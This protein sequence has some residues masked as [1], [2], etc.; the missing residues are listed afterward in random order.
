LAGSASA[1][2][3]WF[4]KKY[5]VF[6]GGVLKQAK[7]EHLIKERGIQYWPRTPH[8]KLATDAETLRAIAQRC[9]E[10]ATFC[11]GKTT[12]DQL[13]TFKLTVGDDDRNR[14][15]LSAFASKTSRNQPSNSKFAFGLNAAFCSV[16]KP[17]FGRAIA[18]LDFS[19]QEFAIAAYSSG[20][21]NMIQAYESGDP[22]SDWARKSG[23]MPADGNKKTHPGVRAV[24]KRASLGVIYG[25]GPETMGEYVG[26]STA[27]AREL[28]RSHR[29]TFPTFWRWSNAVYNSAIVTR[30][31]QTVF[32]WRMH[33]RPDA[34]MR[35]LLNYPMQSNGAEMLRLSCCYAVDRG[36]HIVAPI[37]DAILLESSSDQIDADIA[38]LKECMIAASRAVLGGPAVRVDASDPIHYPDRY[39]DG[40]DG[41]TELWE[42]VMSLLEQLKRRTA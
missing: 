13:K 9:P 33:V 31:L 29:Q 23:A 6:E 7:L 10:M 17:S 28:L 32:G 3:R 36:L 4:N 34:K 21:R 18:Y 40:R 39:V 27:R 8:G 20:D 12:L 30:E 25:M 1:H 26:V 35:T 24:Y 2:H 15:M 38:S 11:L 37:H 41:A 5:P 22:Y 14:C 19:G 42:M 16:I